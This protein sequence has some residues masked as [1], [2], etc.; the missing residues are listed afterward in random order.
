VY[1]VTQKKG[2]IAGVKALHFRVHNCN[3]EYNIIDIGKEKF[4]ITKRYKVFNEK[5]ISSFLLE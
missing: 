1:D 3:S 2:L 5:E 4:L